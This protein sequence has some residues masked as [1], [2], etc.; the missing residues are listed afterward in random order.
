[1]WR[2]TP[3]VGRFPLFW[4]HDYPPQVL[5]ECSS[6]QPPWRQRWDMVPYTFWFGMHDWFWPLWF[7]GL[8]PNA[9]SLSQTHTHKHTLEASSL[10]Q[11][12][13]THPRCHTIWLTLL[14]SLDVVCSSSFDVSSCLSLRSLRPGNGTIWRYDGS[15]LGGQSR[16]LVTPL[17]CK[18]NLLFISENCLFAV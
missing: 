15:S 13:T 18:H 16:T 9:L 6:Q 7:A 2:L 10:T 12:H 5:S 17:A 14:I 4:L 1:M 11:M 3:S 8:V